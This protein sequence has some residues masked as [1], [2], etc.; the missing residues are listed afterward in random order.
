MCKSVVTALVEKV[1][2]IET[3]LLDFYYLAFPKDRR[4]T[5]WLVCGIYILELT[6][7]ILLTHDAFGTYATHY[8]DDGFLNNMQL[9]PL[10]V[11]IFSGMGSYLSNV[12][13]SFCGL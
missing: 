2:R 3:P 1:E 13:R 6:Q 5:K 8:G 12:P 11:P 4:I 10:S 9:I 7:T